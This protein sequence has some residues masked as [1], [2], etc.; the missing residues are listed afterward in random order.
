MVAIMVVL[1]LAASAVGGA[2]AS[3]QV[4]LAG[5]TLGAVAGA[6]PMSP[7][8]ALTAAR[9]TAAAWWIAPV[10]RLVGVGAAAGPLVGLAIAAVGWGG[11]GLVGSLG[12]AAAVVPFSLSCVALGMVLGTVVGE[13]TAGAVGF[14][15]VWMGVL[16]PSAVHDLL[17]GV[18]YLQRPMVFVWNAM[19][20]TWRARR[21]LRGNVGD[22]LM[23]TG[24]MALCI[25]FTAAAAER[26]VGWTNAGR[27]NREP[28]HR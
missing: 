25:L 8:A 5:G 4:V 1:G 2:L 27:R 26:A 14:I 11:G 17:T 3:T 21:V 19:P 10:G 28:S 24:C 16:P 20:L 9:R 7:G 18:P 13:S 15:A 23:L 6:L 22:V 12:T